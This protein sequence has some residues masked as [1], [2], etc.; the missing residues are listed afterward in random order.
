MSPID[1]PVAVG[2]I[3]R[4]RLYNLGW[5]RVLGERGW[6]GKYIYF[7]KKAL[8]VSGCAC[9]NGEDSA[10]GYTSI[11][12]VCVRCAGLFAPSAD[13]IMSWDPTPRLTELRLA[14]GLSTGPADFFICPSPSDQCA[15]KLAEAIIKG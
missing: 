6:R 5:R 3:S 15:P 8:K 9:G 14:A 2:I 11:R 7:F 4:E 1:P 10:T 13:R 12:S